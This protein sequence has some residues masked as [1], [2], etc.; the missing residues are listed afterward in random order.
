MRVAARAT[1]FR[2]A[3]FRACGSFLRV[4]HPRPFLIDGPIGAKVDYTTDSCR[5]GESLL[6]SISGAG[7]KKT[8]QDEHG[9]YLIDH[10]TPMGR[11]AAGGIQMH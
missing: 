11:D 7:V 5:S 10:S 3:D 8:L 6:N 1:F 4:R 2:V 9:G